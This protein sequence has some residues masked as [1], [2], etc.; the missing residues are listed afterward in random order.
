MSALIF[1]LDGTLIDASRDI[2]ACAIRMLESEGLPPVTLDQVRGFI[3]NGVGVL[4]SRCLAALEVAETP[5]LHG[6]MTAVFQQEYVTAVTRTTLFPHVRETLQLLK[7]DG[8]RLALCTNK[9]QA[10][11][12]AVLD[13]LGLTPLFDAFA[14]GDGPYPRK[15][16]P[17]PVRH[18]VDQLPA[19]RF[20]YV[21]DSE[22]D[23]ETARN[24][25]IP[26]ALFTEGHRKTPPSALYHDALF[27]DFKQLPAIAAGL[28]PRPQ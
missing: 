15:P 9:P 16:D 6:R 20:L 25:K 26:M 27:N 5:A 13:H 18:L 21:G 22:V 3:G 12:H 24:A 23:C 14:Y 1:D 8:Y 11:T 28:V 7:D 17:A 10:P 4:I 2:H 19:R